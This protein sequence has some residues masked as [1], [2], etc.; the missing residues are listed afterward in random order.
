MTILKK[1]NPS[2]SL[3]CILIISKWVTNINVCSVGFLECK[4]RNVSRDDSYVYQVLDNIVDTTLSILENSL[5]MTLDTKHIDRFET[6]KQNCYNWSWAR[7][8][9]SCCKLKRKQVFG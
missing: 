1:H 2:V 9:S 6:F 5:D 4:F 3:T 7:W 8:C